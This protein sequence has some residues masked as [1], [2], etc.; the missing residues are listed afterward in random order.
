MS[1]TA[2]RSSCGGIDKGGPDDLWRSSRTS[3]FHP[4]RVTD[5]IDEMHAVLSQESLSQS[6]E[7]QNPSPHHTCCNSKRLHLPKS[8]QV[9][10]TLDTQGVCRMRSILIMLVT[11]SDGRRSSKSQSQS[12]YA[13]SGAIYPLSYSS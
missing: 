7:K 1:L 5:V 6:K 10:H 4:H 2:S 12:H 13:S 9:V 8:L 3:G 11:A